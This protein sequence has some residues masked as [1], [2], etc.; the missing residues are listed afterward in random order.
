ML[1]NPRNFKNSPNLLLLFV[2]IRKIL[3]F[4][5]KITKKNYSF[6]ELCIKVFPTSHIKGIEFSVTDCTVEDVLLDMSFP[7]LQNTCPS[8]I[9]QATVLST[10]PS[11]D[12]FGLEYR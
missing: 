5:K 10:N 11:I 8:H 12:Y 6:F 3:E 9:V 2:K 7:I 4:S 1:E